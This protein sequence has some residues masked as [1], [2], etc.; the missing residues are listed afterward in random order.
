[1]SK[2]NKKAVA[3]VLGA[4]SIGAGYGAYRKAKKWELG[5]AA[6]VIGGALTIIAAVF[7]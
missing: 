4:C 3:I 5:S 1:M 7:G 6:N 2:N